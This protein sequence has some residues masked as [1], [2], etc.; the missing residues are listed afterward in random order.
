METAR[1]E[2]EIDGYMLWAGINQ[3]GHDAPWYGDI[4]LSDGRENG[5]RRHHV[6]QDRRFTSAA[7]AL[8]YAR[9]RLAAVTGV[10]PAG[11]LLF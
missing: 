1:Y 6:L 10:T 11:D 9:E 2:R 5:V 8:D 4:G 7:S 3:P